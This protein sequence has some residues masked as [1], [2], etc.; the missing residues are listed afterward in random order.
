M[1]NCLYVANDM[2]V[3]DKMDYVPVYFIALLRIIV[4]IV[5]AVKV[6]VKMVKKIIKPSIFLISNK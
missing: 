2:D 5:L 1:S 3:K 4:S 6:A